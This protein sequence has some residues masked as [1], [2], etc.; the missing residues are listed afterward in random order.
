VVPREDGC[1]L[2]SASC[3]TGWTD[4]IHGELWLCPSGLL[5]RSLDLAVTM[6]HGANPTVDPARRPTRWFTSGE[7]AQITQSNRRNR[8][9]PWASIST[10][11]AKRGPLTDSLH[12]ELNDGGQS[13]FLWL[14]V[15][16]AMGLVAEAAAQHLG[17]RF[18]GLR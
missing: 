6:R 8:W 3:T 10:A 4:W 15:D 18:V 14:K 7:I 13:K 9:V 17:N 12:V 1:I 16:D 11:S 5:R 2:L